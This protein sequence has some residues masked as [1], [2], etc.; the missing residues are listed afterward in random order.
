MLSALTLITMRRPSKKPSR[1]FSADSHRLAE[2][3]QALI[4]ASSRLEERAWEREIETLLGKHF[5]AQHQEP[6]DSALED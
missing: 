1:K 4:Q 6:I 3:A 5:K 2:L